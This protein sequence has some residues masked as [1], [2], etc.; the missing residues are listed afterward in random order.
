MD[1]VIHHP[2]CQFEEFWRIPA[3]FSS[4][5]IFRRTG[6]A[7]ASSQHRQV[8]YSFCSI[9][10]LI[11]FIY[12]FILCKLFIYHGN[13]Y[14]HKKLHYCLD[15]LHSIQSQ[16]WKPASNNSWVVSSVHCIF[17][18]QTILLPRISLTLSPKSSP[19][20]LPINRCYK[21]VKAASTHRKRYLLLPRICFFLNFFWKLYWLSVSHDTNYWYYFINYSE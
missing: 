4:R 7:L 10:V 18:I 20:G 2:T 12:N 21:P 19:S 14:R 15:C 8:E 3:A 5:A 16:K 17:Q 9:F 1:S 6:T 11:I 13:F